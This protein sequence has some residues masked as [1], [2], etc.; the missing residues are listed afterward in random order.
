MRNC[1]GIDVSKKSLDMYILPTDQSERFSNDHA[2]ILQ[3]VKRCQQEQPALIVM[4]ATGGYESLLAGTLQAEELAVAVVNPRR[5]R[6]FARA[7]GQMAKTDA[8]DAKII[9]HYG[10]ILEPAPTE[11]MDDNA[12]KLKALVSRRHQLVQMHTAESNRI[13]HAIDK[14]IKSSLVAVVRTIEKQIEKIDRQIKDHIDQQPELKQRAESLKTVPGIGDTTAH[15]LVTELPE[16]GCYNRRQI[17]AL[18]GVAPM[19]R[20]SGMFRGKRMT[21][22][23]RRLVRAR[24]FMPTLVAVKY[25]PTLRAY[26]RRLVEQQGKCKMVA[27]TAAMRKLLCIMN[28]MLKNNQQWNENLTETT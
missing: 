20:D 13:E 12:R 9:A 7:S 3:C 15:M 10:A 23:G 16:L 6:D 19:N 25:N 14:E 17:A 18:V 28:T 2:G 24:L 26:Y 4:E 8:L 11:Q 22:G 5:I 1:I 21:G 27:L